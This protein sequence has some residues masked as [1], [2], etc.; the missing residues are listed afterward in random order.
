MSLIQCTAQLYKYV[1]IDLLLP[2]AGISFCTSVA[3]L[4]VE[5]VM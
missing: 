4:H 1:D 5:E 2:G 3:L